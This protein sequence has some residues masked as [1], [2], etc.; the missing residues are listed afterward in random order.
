MQTP[1][2]LTLRTLVDVN[3]NNENPNMQAE[4]K[5]DESVY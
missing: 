5:P 4:K 2:H 1:G 3:S